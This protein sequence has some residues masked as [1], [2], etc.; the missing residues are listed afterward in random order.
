MGQTISSR[1]CGARHPGVRWTSSDGRF[2]Y[3]LW[4]LNYRQVP[5]PE[6]MGY[7]LSRF[8]SVA[9]ESEFEIATHELLAASEQL[10]SAFKTDAYIQRAEVRDREVVHEVKRALK[11]LSLPHKGKVRV[12]ALWPRGLLL[13]WGTAGI[14]ISHTTEGH[15]DDGMLSVQKPFVIAHEMAHGYGV[16][17]EGACNF[18]AWL[19]CRQSED[20]WV[21]FSGAL[22]YWRYVA[23]EMERDVVKSELEKMPE[24]VSRTIQLIRENDRK[25]PD[26]LPQLRDLI[27]NNYLKG[28]GVREGMRSY[29]F[30]VKMVHAYRTST[31]PVVE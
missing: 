7:E 10:P 25:Y 6:R 18:I 15:I 4:G 28:H 17:D 13:R 5:L 2:F 1:D 31:L 11:E 26:I 29:N 20:P 8:D 24:M 16:T 14:Y 23:V 3:W 12:R 19:A 27:Y 21:R 22:S 30:V 9:L